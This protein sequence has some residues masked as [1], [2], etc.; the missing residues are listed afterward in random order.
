M[1]LYRSNDQ[2]MN[3]NTCDYVDYE[4]E[5]EVGVYIDCKP[6]RLLDGSESYR[7]YTREE[8]EATYNW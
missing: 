1:K 8:F 2:W 3:T 5:D 7:V 6:D 4:Y